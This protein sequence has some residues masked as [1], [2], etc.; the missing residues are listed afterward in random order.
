MIYSEHT[1][2]VIQEMTMQKYIIFTET[3]AINL[4]NVAY[5][6][7][8]PYNDESIGI[9]FVGSANTDTLLLKRQGGNNGTY[10]K[11]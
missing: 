9:V 11:R 3:K 1:H 10:K 6:D 2:S 7:L 5:V 8:D 4:S